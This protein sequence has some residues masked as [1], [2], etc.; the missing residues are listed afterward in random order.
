MKGRSLILLWLIAFVAGLWFGGGLARWTETEPA[1]AQPSQAKAVRA[2]A[3]EL[4]DKKGKLRAKL[5]MGKDEEPMLVV[6]DKNEKPAAA[7]G[8]NSEGPVQDFLGK[9]LRP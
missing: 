1:F 2:E 7:Y 9:I 6:Y 3:F 4:V 8:L 5:M